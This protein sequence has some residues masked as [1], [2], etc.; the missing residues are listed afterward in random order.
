MGVG[1]PGEAEEGIEGDRF[2]LQIG[3]SQGHLQ[4]GGAV[5]Q[6]A[7]RREAEAITAGEEAGDGPGGAVLHRCGSDL[8]GI[9]LRK[10]LHPAGAGE[11]GVAKVHGTVDSVA[12]A[13]CRDH[14]QFGAGD[15]L[16]LH[17]DRIE[18]GGFVPPG[19]TAQAVPAVDHSGKIK[20]PRFGGEDLF[21]KERSAAGRR[22]GEAA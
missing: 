3:L 6:A 22:E 10:E 12:G 19:R 20:I 18:E 1:D 14:D 4:I 15:S 21:P 9:P 8:Q 7:G 16:T 17:P 13:R 5:G 2:K 11:I